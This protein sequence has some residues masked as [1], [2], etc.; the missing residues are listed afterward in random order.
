M[1]AAEQE[2]VRQLEQA[3]IISRAE[4][5]AQRGCRGGC[6]KGCGLER[7][8]RAERRSKHSSRRSMS[9]APQ[10]DAVRASR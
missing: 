3:A 8:G 2:R 6:G 4:Q 9:C 1:L 10:L 7:H 5:E